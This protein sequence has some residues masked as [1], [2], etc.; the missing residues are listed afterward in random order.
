M[1]SQTLWYNPGRTFST[2][3]SRVQQGT[4]T[5]LFNCSLTILTRCFVV[6]GGNTRLEASYFTPMSGGGSLKKISILEKQL[7]FCLLINFFS[8]YENV[9]KQ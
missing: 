3:A 8:I 9:Q 5:Y 2:E 6:S 1:T 7:L 4:D